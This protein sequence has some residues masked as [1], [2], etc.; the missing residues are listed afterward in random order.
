MNTKKGGMLWTRLLKVAPNFACLFENDTC[1]RDCVFYKFIE[2]V[3]VR[4]N[5][6]CT[7]NVTA[8]KFLRFLN[9]FDTTHDLQTGTAVE[10]IV[11][12]FLG[13]FGHRDRYSIV[14]V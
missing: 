6:S 11:N 5:Y 2:C 10:E 12:T 13:E 4:F 9:G 7:E 14:I 8:E 3:V 1:F